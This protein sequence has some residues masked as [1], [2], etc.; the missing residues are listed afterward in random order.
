MRTHRPQSSPFGGLPYRILYMNP[1]K[2]LLLGPMRS[3]IRG[4]SR[5]LQWCFRV[6]TSS[7][8]GSARVLYG[9]GF[10]V[11]GWSLGLKLSC[12]PGTLSFS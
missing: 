7:F 12:R 11:L 5:A 8:E 9:F 2:E 1:T 4:P 6:T 10:K 3:A